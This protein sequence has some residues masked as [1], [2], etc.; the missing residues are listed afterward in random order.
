VVSNNGIE[1]NPDKVKAMQAMSSPKTEKQVRI[2]LGRLNYIAQFI[3]QLTTTCDI[4]FWLLRKKNPGVWDEDY[5]EAFDKIKQYFQKSPLSVLPILRK[6]L[7]LYWTITKS[8]M[9]C[10]L[11]QHDEYER[12]EQAIYYFSKKFTECESCY[13]II[14]KLCCS[15]TWSANRLRQYM[16]YYATWLISKMEPLKYIFEKPYMSSRIVR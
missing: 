2:F 8:T 11:W 12:K 10:V 15:L 6:P 7:I 16:L 5:Q 14:E 13:S 1:I 9:G 3:P 4:I